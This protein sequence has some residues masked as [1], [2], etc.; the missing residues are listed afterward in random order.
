[1]F[2]GLEVFMGDRELAS[3]AM[4]RHHALMRLDRLFAPSRYSAF[5]WHRQVIEHELVMRTAHGLTTEQL[6][7][8]MSEEQS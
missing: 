1:M 8:L 6:L 3:D 4:I 5:P 2:G 7:E